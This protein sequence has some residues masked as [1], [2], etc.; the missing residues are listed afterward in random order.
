MC[1]T[2]TAPDRFHLLNKQ[3][4]N[5]IVDYKIFEF[6]VILLYSLLIQ[7]FGYSPKQ[8]D[9]KVMKFEA[10]TAGL[11]LCSTGITIYKL[12]TILIAC[13]INHFILFCDSSY[14]TRAQ[15]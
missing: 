11:T 8:N 3:H 2:P 12:Y 6:N 7:L 15:S 14:P 5:N 4:K 10:H 9:E 13:E 1:T